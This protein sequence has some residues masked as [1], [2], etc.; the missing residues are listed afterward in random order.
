MTSRVSQRATRIKACQLAA[1][2]LQNHE[3]D[4]GK[5]MSLCVFF[6]TYIETGA[7]ATEQAM[8][9]LSRRKVKGFKVIA[10]GRL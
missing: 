8:H 7:D 2:M 10:G 6:E 5:L 4:G 1:Q 9:L 3:Y